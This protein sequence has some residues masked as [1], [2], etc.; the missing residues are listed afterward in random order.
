LRDFSTERRG[1]FKRVKS[2]F[3]RIE[4]GAQRFLALSAFAVFTLRGVLFKAAIEQKAP[5][6]GASRSK[7]QSKTNI[8]NTN[9]YH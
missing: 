3:L 9:I 5:L 6:S 8:V 7:W 4:N 2:A 1:R